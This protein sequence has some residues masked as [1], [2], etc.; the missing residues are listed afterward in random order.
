MIDEPASMGDESFDR[1]AR[2]VR[3]MLDV[4]VALVS[5]VEQ[6]R[7]V[8]P[9]AAGLSEPYRTTRETSLSHSLCRHVVLDGRPLVIRD[10]RE[11]ER[12]RGNLA[13]DELDAIAYAGWPLTDRSGQI[14][15][16]VC[17]IDSRPRVWSADE[18]EN[19]AD[20]AAACSAELAQREL[21]AEAA[22]RAEAA[23]LS[24]HRDQTLLA[25]SEALAATRTLGDISGAVERAARDLMSC[26]HAGIWVR[27]PAGSTLV[28]SPSPGLP[29]EGSQQLTFVSN[30]STSWVQAARN[31]V[32]GVDRGNP[33]GEA[34]LD[35]AP[36]YFADRAAVGA[37]YPRLA[38]PAHSG[39]A[40][41]VVPLTVGLQGYGA[42]LLVWPEPRV[43]SVADRV[44]LSALTIY[45]AQAVHRALMLQERVD[46]AMTLQRAMMTRLPQPEGLEL[47][48]RYRPAAAR[49]E[50]GGDWYDAVEMSSG[51]T[52]LMIGD[53]VGHDV[54]AA[55]VMGQLRSMLR[56][57]AWA[58]DER[59]S[60]NVERL[61]RATLQMDQDTL[62]TLL[63]ARLEQPSGDRS[64]RHRTLRWTNAGHLPP[65]LIDPDGSTR[66]LDDDGP[67]DCMLGVVPE[68]AR[69]D[70]TASIR[71]GSTLLF[72][73]DGLVERRG[74]SIDVG[75][76][77]VQGVAARHHRLRLGDFLDATLEE[78]VP[79][80][81]SDDVAVLAVRLSPAAG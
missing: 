63:Y 75:L 2:M 4:P 36:L 72:F 77:R 57:F 69:R 52:S 81:P 60:R 67:V 48:A 23:R 21:R 35:G 68:R 66:L 1:Y 6:T 73:T 70:Q 5:L 14:V 71:A 79:V 56:A 17:A 50:V 55:A 51:E 38:P 62:A 53:V 46:V 61:D 29:S 3:R 39:E 7:Q 47:A 34:L 24:A 45:T 30:E 40:R 32:L 49:D 12:L 37:R 58:L 27:Q 13:I 54:V 11:D 22:E 10:A 44:A 41:A 31:S 59:P 33:L 65:L 80:N 15:G 20:L 19:L 18:L 64:V 8:F 76:E 78:L 25:L 42:L 16:S 43:F 26:A 28:A 9:G 74:E